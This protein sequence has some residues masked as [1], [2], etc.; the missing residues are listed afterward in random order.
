[1]LIRKSTRIKV[2]AAITAAVIA[3]ALFTIADSG[4]YLTLRSRDTGKLYARFRLNE[5]ERFS[6]T[7]IHSVN[8]YPLT[9]VY[10][11]YD[12]T[13]YVE[14]CIYCAF[15]TGVETELNEG[16]I[17]DHM[18]IDRDDYRGTAMVVKNIHQDRSN[19]GYI[20]GTI[21]DHILTIDGEE[22]SLRDLCGRNSAVRFNYEYFLW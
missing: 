15:G 9:D 1:M 2:A 22:I 5:G 14:E 19:V 20:V 7:F 6:V 16:E 3:A 13:I 12:Q 4:Y 11:I 18:Y 21:Y 10:E 17:L 8:K